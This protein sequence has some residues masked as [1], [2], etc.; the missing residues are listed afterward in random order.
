MLSEVGVELGFEVIPA[1]LF[2]DT[3]RWSSTSVRSALEV[4]DLESTQRILGH[5]FVLRGTVEHGDARGE[6][7]GF[8]TAN[9]TLAP[10]Q[11]LPGEGVYAGATQLDGAWW[12]A[13]ISVGTRPQFYEDGDLLVE[14]HLPGFNGDLYGADLDTVF[15]SRLRD[16]MTFSNVSELTQQIRTDVDKTLQIFE[17]YS[18]EDA[19]LLR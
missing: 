9:L 18:S 1:P 14:V 12:A 16:Q 19:E 11:A 13:A 5:P 15:L 10:R 3:E 17:K 2:G 6:E 7:L 4:G 8:P